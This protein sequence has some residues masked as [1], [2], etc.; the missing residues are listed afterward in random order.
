MRNYILLLLLLPITICAQTNLRGKVVDAET[1][2]PLA[3]AHIYFNGDDRQVTSTDIEG[4]FSFKNTVS[5]L[6]CNYMGY[7]NFSMSILPGQKEI[8]V[9]LVKSKFELT[10]VVVE[11]G[12]NPANGIIRKVIA[13][14]E[15]NNPENITTFKYKSY[16][17][18]IYDFR[19]GSKNK[20]DSI[21]LREKMKGS[22]LFM[23]E[24]VSERKFIKPDISEEVVIATKVSGFKNP[25][26]ASLATDFQP[27][28]FYKDNIKL[29]DINYL[30]PISNGSLKKYKF[31][32]E[33]TIFQQK[34][35]VYV[36]SFQPRKNKN[37]EGLKGFLY[38][39][40]NKYAIQNVI[41]SPFEKGK[42]D[43]KIQQQYVFVDNKYWF[44]EQLN[45]ALIFNEFPT[46]AI[47]MVLNGKSYIDEVEV[48]IPLSKKEFALESV[49]MDENAA[50]KDSLFWK[51]FRPEALNFNEKRTYTFIDSIGEKANFDSMMTLMEKLAK[52]KIPVKFID[53]DLAKTF[54]YNKYEGFRLG[55]GLYTNDKLFKKLTLGGFFGY[56]LEDHEWKYGGEFLYEISKKNEI[57]IG[58]KYQQN[59]METG[60]YG[61]NTYE[62]NLY[63]FRNYLGFQYD[64]I[65]QENLNFGF[66]TLRY[67]K[68]NFDLNHTKV[69]PRYDYEFQNDGDIF[70]NYVNTDFTMN[71]RFAYKEKFVQ[72][73]NTRYSVETKFPVLNVSY[74]KGLK[75]FIDGDFSYNKIET[76]LQHSFY[77]KNF[78]QTSYRIEGGFVDNPLPYGLL[79]TGEGSYD[80]KT[81]I[82]MK[83]TFQTMRPY[84]F[85]SDKYANLFLSHNFGGLLFKSGKFQPGVT[86]HNNFGWGN[87]SNKSAHQ[88]IDFKIKNKVF[89]ET[90]LQIDNIF[91]LNYMN[92]ANLGLGFGAYYRYGEY[93]NEES[94][95]NLVFKFSMAFS[96]K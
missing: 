50:K 4:K 56:G 21:T 17:K 71:L 41:A 81:A 84:E 6:T 36:L 25:S 95:D 72:S 90:G 48:D 7:Q 76:S 20:N 64:M 10:E 93:A 24:S 44:P 30:N 73:L 54:S 85:L 16:N 45:Y 60:N 38:V 70:R 79:F 65:R 42:I 14:K 52:G 34:D 15:K 91:K 32:I 94:N 74:S 62:P 49:R 27:F 37:F 46:P 78:G 8:I 63:N 31:K 11:S 51:K 2:E 96:I 47:G 67:L 40:T 9:E 23:M 80:K 1:K 29:F 57:I 18:L 89:T 13:N 5:R 82:I 86:W 43:I 87:L 19:T 92:I 68:L 83:N 69:A 58:A 59:L 26:F 12:E 55:T 3:F 88:L 35:T 22:H 33:D 39:N 61:L 53:I 75:N 77:T 28:S 66:R